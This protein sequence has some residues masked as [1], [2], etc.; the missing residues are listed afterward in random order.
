MQSVRMYSTATCPYCL[1]AKA[2]LRQRGV[3]TIDEIRIDER[4]TERDAMIRLTQRWTV[5]QI[6]IGETHIGGCDDLVAL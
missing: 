2:L 4:P 1:R 6:F 5:P 3:E